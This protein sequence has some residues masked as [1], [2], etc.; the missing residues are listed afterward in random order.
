V[1]MPIRALTVCDAA[2]PTRSVATEQASNIPTVNI[3]VKVKK[4]K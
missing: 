2:S 3:T 4:V 1:T